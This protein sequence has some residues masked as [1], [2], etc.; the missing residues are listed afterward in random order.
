MLPG[1]TVFDADRIK[2]L[3]E[4][5]PSKRFDKYF[6]AENLYFVKD[7]LHQQSF[8]RAMQNRKGPGVRIVSGFA[9]VIGLTLLIS[10]W[11]YYH[12]ST[13]GESTEHLFLANYR[14]VQYATAMKEVVEQMIDSDS[15]TS[16]R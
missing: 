14:S 13:L 9:V 2:V 11:S 6:A 16:Q 10:A 12:I 7:S 15:L 8:E 5:L 3:R 4:L 1:Q